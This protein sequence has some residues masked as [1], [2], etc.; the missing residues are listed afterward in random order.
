MVTRVP[1]HLTTVS[2]KSSN[3]MWNGGETKPVHR[4]KTNATDV[5]CC[6]D[7]LPKYIPTLARSCH[8][9]FDLPPCSLLFRFRAYT[10]QPNMYV[11]GELP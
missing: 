8:F 10:G 2:N 4:F 5:D 9:G 1:A 11:V 3:S 7:I 6:G